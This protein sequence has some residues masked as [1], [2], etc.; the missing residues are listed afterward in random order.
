MYHPISFP[1]LGIKDFYID[2]VAFSFFGLEVRWYG[3][4]I[5][6]GIIFAYLLAVRE[7]KMQGFDPEILTDLLLFAL[8]AS[9][10]GARIY[11]VIFTW[12]SYKDNPMRALNIREGGLAIYGAVIA[13]IITT[14][15]FCKIKKISFSKV[16]DIASP[17]LILGQAIGRWG[18]FVNQEAYGGPTNLPWAMRI[19]DGIHYI[20][21]HPTFLYES[22]WNFGVFSFLLWY[23]K[24]KKIEGEIFMLYLIGYGLGRVWIEGLRV[25]SLYIGNFR[26]SQLLA[27]ILVIGVSLIWINKRKS[28]NKIH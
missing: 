27:G 23:R 4:I 13:A 15:V 11:Y 1:N 8:P 3:L 24:K 7:S 26:A 6:T 10:I 25:D 17:S 9:I 12:E 2:P 19:Y 28:D 16:A 18:N 22:L 5:T 20:T 21:V 14:I